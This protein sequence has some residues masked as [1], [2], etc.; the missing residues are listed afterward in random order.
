MNGYGFP[1]DGEHVSPAAARAARQV[2]G[3]SSVGSLRE[4]ARRG[5]VRTG[6]RAHGAAMELEA[7][8][9]SRPRSPGA[10]AGLGAAAEK[11]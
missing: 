10:D 8:R 11:M 3:L 2:R 5:P 1:D 4:V 6:L 9:L 7:S